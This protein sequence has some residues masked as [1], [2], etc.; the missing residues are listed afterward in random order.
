[1]NLI[2]TD[3]NDVGNPLTKGLARKGSLMLAII[4]PR[5]TRRTLII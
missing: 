5:M 4:K 1:M 2:N 3:Y